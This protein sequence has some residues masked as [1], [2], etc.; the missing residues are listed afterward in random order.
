MAY[1]TPVG[2][3]NAEILPSYSIPTR[4]LPIAVNILA[5]LVLSAWFK[6][7]TSVIRQSWYP[8]LLVTVMSVGSLLAAIWVSNEAQLTAAAALLEV[9]LPPSIL[10][11][12][13]AGRHMSSL[14]LLLIAASFVGISSACLCIEMQRVF[15]HL[16]SQYVL[17]IGCFAMLVSSLV[18]FVLSFGPELLQQAVFIFSPLPIALGVRKT[19]RKI[20]TKGFYTHGLKAQLFIPYRFLITALLHGLAIGVTIG[21]SLLL[22]ESYGA[23]HLIVLS[24]ALAAVLLF[25]ITVL[26]RSDYNHLIYQIGFPLVALGALLMLCLSGLTEIGLYVQLLGFCFLHLAMWGVCTYFIKNLNLPATWVIATLII[27]REGNRLS[28]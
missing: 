27:P 26:F 23:V 14:A 2:F 11:A 25:T 6:R 9:D 17:F 24:Y 15:G 28:C 20:N 1:Q 10:A 21:F 22:G 8:A 12:G 4:L 18:I 7:S 19:V 13:D 3:P 5:Y 16:G